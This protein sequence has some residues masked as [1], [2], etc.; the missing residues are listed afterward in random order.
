MAVMGENN[1]CFKIM[2][3]FTCFVCERP[4]NHWSVCPYCGE[5]IS[6][7]PR[8]SLIIFIINHL[9]LLLGLLFFIFVRYP[10][11]A[12]SLPHNLSGNILIALPLA[13]LFSS[14]LRQKVIFFD[15]KH[16]FLRNFFDLV[17]GFTFSAAICMYF[18][19]L[20]KGNVWNHAGYFSAVLLPIHLCLL[21]VYYRRVSFY[22]FFAGICIALALAEIV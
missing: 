12:I 3:Y 1:H 10:L 19:A 2:R 20:L 22:P 18:L 7:I 15:R 4:I 11:S 8:K 5:K 14:Y 6:K 17:Y 16:F 21:Y 13:V 9:I